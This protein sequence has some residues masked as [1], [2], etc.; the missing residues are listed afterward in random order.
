MVSTGGALYIN[1]CILAL[2]YTVLLF[3]SFSA[4]GGCLLRSSVQLSQPNLLLPA[5]SSGAVYWFRQVSRLA[6]GRLVARHQRRRLTSRVCGERLVGRRVGTGGGGRL[7]SILGL[8]NV[9]RQ[10]VDHQVKVDVI[11]LVC[12]TLSCGGGIGVSVQLLTGIAVRL[13]LL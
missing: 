5:S 12:V 4:G 2:L 7:L 6:G 10:A 11:L 3:S 1:S 13:Q 8:I 9:K